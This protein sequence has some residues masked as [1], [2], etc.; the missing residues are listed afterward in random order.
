MGC[1]RD[2]DVHCS[3]DCFLVLLQNVILCTTI[4]IYRI[5]S[6]P[7]RAIQIQRD[8]PVN[9]ICVKYLIFFHRRNKII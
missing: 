5:K 8:Y 1:R 3:S 7:L 4:S 9:V 6:I 2:V